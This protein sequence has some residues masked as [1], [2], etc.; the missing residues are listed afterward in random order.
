M[1]L[2]RNNFLG[3]ETGGIEE[4][5]STP[6]GASASSVDPRTGGF[7]LLLVNGNCTI[8]PFEN[9]IDAGDDYILGFG[10]KVVD[11]TPS[12]S[13]SF[14]EAEQASGGEDQIRLNLNTSGTLELRDSSGSQVDSVATP[15]TDGQ[16]H[17]IELWWQHSNT[18]AAKVFIDNAEVMSV[19][20][21]DFLNGTFD[22]YRF[23]GNTATDVEFDDIYCLSGAADETDRLRDAEVFGYRH[24]VTGATPDAGGGGTAGVD[25]DAGGWED[26]DDS[27]DATNG[28]YTGSGDR[29]TVD[30]DG[31]GSDP[32]SSGV[33]AT[34][35]VGAKLYARVDRD[36]GPATTHALYLGDSGDGNNAVEYDDNTDWGPITQDP[37]NYLIVS[38]TNLP[39]ETQDIRAGFGTLGAQDIHMY[40]GMVFLLLVPG[41]LGQVWM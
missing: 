7:S 12:Q 6:G 13:L 36:G 21:E 39:T 4:L 24:S 14:F 17:F 15:F 33:G 11:A 32:D 26:T 2:T 41:L 27:S 22:Q 29:G 8:D 40:D 28:E 10:F 20:S 31:P 38:E 30:W 34:S 35:F 23:R 1:A 25:L 18:G 37:A 9:T 3:F 19:A 16:W 5:L